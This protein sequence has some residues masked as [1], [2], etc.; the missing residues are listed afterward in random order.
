MRP[1]LSRQPKTGSC[2]LNCSWIGFAGSPTFQPTCATPAAQR[3]ATSPSWM[4][5][6]SSRS[7]RFSQAGG[8]NTPRSRSAQNSSITLASVVRRQQ[9][10]ARGIQRE[11]DH[12]ADLGGRRQ[13]RLEDGAGLERDLDVVLTALILH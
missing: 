12:A 1:S 3:R 5:Y 8:K 2:T 9:Y 6:A 7:S 13:P 4:R 11:P 10:H